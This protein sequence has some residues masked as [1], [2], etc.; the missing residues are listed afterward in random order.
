MRS[1]G[2]TLDDERAPL[3]SEL[4]GVNAMPR[5]EF[6]CEKCKQPFELI[7]TISEREK[8]TPM[9][10]KCKG[11]KVVPQFSAFMAQTSK[12]S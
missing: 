11:D 12:R 2:S 3:V 9:C 10:L 8:T 5:Y 6:L 4:N 1:F 7:M